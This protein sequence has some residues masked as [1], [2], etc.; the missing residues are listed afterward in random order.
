MEKKRKEM[1]KGSF[2]DFSENCTQKN[3]TQGKVFKK[4]FTSWKK[5]HDE[6]FYQIL[7]SS[8]PHILETEWNEF[9]PQNEMC[10]IFMM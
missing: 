2:Q 9:V 4:I 3:I 6:K 10:R 5:H 1:V 8:Y 7:F